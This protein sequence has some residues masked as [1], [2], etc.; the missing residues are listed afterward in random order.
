VRPYKER[1]FLKA[2]ALNDREREE[3]KALGPRTLSALMQIDS[4]KNQSLRPAK[5]MSRRMQQALALLAPLA[6]LVALPGFAQSVVAISGPPLYAQARSLPGVAEAAEIDAPQPQPSVD[7]SAGEPTTALAVVPHDQPGGYEV[8]P[9]H[10]KY[11]LP[12][13]RAQTL[14]PH[15]KMLIALQDV[16]SPLNFGG[17]IASAGYEQLRNGQP[18]YGTDRGAF[19][20]R[21]GA[22]GIRD[23]AQGV[24]TDGV[25][26]PLLHED[27]RY[28]V[29]GPQYGIF[30]RALYAVT[31]PL[32]TRTDSGRGAINGAL[33]LGYASSTALNNAY[34]PSVNRNMRDNAE[35]FAGSLGGAA[36][37]FFVTEFTSS[38]WSD[39]HFGHKQ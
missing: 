8:A 19:G 11:I 25:F 24:F 2:S 17:I 38:L 23:T 32:I 1:Q 4:A 7:N 13:M 26:A 30:H 28:Y 10:T 31:R 29:E 6:F 34:Y 5:R 22:A 36:L 39:L 9:L 15:D 3:G 14:A 18:N 16:Y 37:S 20:E 12:N 33:L 21:L 27:P 35:A